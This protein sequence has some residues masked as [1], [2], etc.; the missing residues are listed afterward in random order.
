M[1]FTNS[2]LTFKSRSTGDEAVF[3]AVR[4][5]KP[6]CVG[7]LVQFTRH[8]ISGVKRGPGLLDS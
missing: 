8:K 7:R 3:T 2:Y 6:D 1:A 4:K 5:P